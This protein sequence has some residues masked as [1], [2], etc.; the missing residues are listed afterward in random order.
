VTDQIFVVSAAMVGVC[1]T[2]LG[3]VGILKT[4][5]SVA[6]ITDELLAADAMVFLA[7]TLSSYLALRTQNPRRAAAYGRIADIS[8]IVAMILVVAIGA[9]VAIHLA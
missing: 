7:A 6:S 1:L 9:I 2:L 5:T 8:F 3:L 4:L